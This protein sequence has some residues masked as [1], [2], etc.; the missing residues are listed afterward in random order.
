[1]PWCEP[2]A[3]YFAP[4][5]LTTDGACPMCGKPVD[6]ATSSRGKATDNVS[7]RDLQRMSGDKAPWHFKLLMAMLVLYL[8][9]RVIAVFVD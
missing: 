7:L 6:L 8:G 5:A 4:T 2:C 1:M 9:W 3:K